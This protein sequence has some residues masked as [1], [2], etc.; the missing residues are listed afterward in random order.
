MLCQYTVYTHK[1]EGD[2][3]VLFILFPMFT[4][5]CPQVFFLFQIY[6]SIVRHSIS[7][8]NESIN[9]AVRRRLI[10]NVDSVVTK[11][12]KKISNFALKYFYL[13]K[14]KD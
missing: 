12:V 8:C 5:L 10:P 3:Q 7:K 4:S 6:C 13:R 9:H 2:V 1:Q 11:S 14:E